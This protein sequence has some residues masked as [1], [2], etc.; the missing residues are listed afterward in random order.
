MS[1]SA[2]IA[3]LPPP[4]DCPFSLSQTG[5]TPVNCA[6]NPS[7]TSNNVCVCACVTRKTIKET[8][9]QGNAADVIDE[10]YQISKVSMNFGVA[11]NKVARDPRT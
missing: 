9:V 2:C 5:K 10:V 4:C 1:F 3:G 6:R 11:T 8:A 7:S